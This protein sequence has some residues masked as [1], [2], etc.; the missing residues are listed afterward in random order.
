MLK[1]GHM[2]LPGAFPG[3]VAPDINFTDEIVAQCY[4]P[5]IKIL[6]Q[7]MIIYKLQQI[8]FDVGLIGVLCTRHSFMYSFS[9]PGVMYS[10]RSLRS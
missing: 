10:F 1:Y 8:N 7:V 3:K 5:V 4:V 2:M 6:L 9:G